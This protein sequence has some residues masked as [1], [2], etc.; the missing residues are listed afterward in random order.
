VFASDTASATATAHAHSS[1][2]VLAELGVKLVQNVEHF[3]DSRGRSEQFCHV[4]VRV[5]ELPDR[6]HRL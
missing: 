2:V 1:C 4:L 5:S 6:L 3:C